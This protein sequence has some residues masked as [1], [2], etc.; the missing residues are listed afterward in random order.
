MRRRQHDLQQQDRGYQA[1]G[2]AK[3][4]EHGQG[5]TRPDAAGKQ[6]A[7]SG[8]SGSSGTR[9]CLVRKPSSGGCQ[10]PA[11]ADRPARGASQA[12]RARPRHPPTRP[13]KPDAGTGA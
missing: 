8:G 12:R 7:A 4:V 3:G 5:V 1:G 6:A 11:A 10:R 9:R 2:V 13:R